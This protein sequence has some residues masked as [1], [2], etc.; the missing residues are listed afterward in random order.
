MKW[1]AHNRDKCRDTHIVEGRNSYSIMRCEH[2]RFGWNVRTRTTVTVTYPLWTV[3][4][5]TP[6]G[7]TVERACFTTLKTA[8]AYIAERTDNE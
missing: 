7:T 5:R 6:R 4:Q 3:Y 2:T 1:D 8:R